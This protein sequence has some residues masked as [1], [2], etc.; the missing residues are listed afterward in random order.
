M[1]PLAQVLVFREGPICPDGEYV[2]N[3]LKAIS[4]DVLATPGIRITTFP[5][6]SWSDNMADLIYA[7]IARNEGNN[8]PLGSL[9]SAILTP[10]HDQY[11][12]RGY[13][14]KVPQP[15]PEQARIAVNGYKV[16]KERVNGTVSM[17]EDKVVKKEKRGFLKMLIDRCKITRR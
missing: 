6:P 1:A 9:S 5:V 16:A 10:F 11:E 2:L 12:T 14:V 4:P 7:I 8:L 13:L 15:S 17:S 3:L